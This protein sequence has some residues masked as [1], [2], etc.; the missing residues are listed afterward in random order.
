[1]KNL[2]LKAS[3]VMKFLAALAG[4]AGI[5][6]S[7]GVI[8]GSAA[9]WTALAISAVTSIGVYLVPNLPAAAPVETPPA[10]PAS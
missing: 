3:T 9:K 6:I 2:K 5:A 10:P 1:L 8:S 4:V 7:Q